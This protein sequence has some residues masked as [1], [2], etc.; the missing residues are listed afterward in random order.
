[1]QQALR[2]LR[3]I[4]SFLIALLGIAVLGLGLKT[5]SPGYMILGYLL[6][7]RP[8]H[9]SRAAKHSWPHICLHSGIP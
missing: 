4:G 3:T 2:K 5:V 7:L 8:R 1:M 6:Y 9:Y